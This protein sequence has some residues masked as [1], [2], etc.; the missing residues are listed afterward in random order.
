MIESMSNFLC[1]ELCCSST[2]V[3]SECA[4]G[5]RLILTNVSVRLLSELPLLAECRF[6]L[7]TI[8]HSSRDDARSLGLPQIG[9]GNLLNTRTR[10][11]PQHQVSYTPKFPNHKPRVLAYDMHRLDPISI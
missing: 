11:P 7:K 1:Y 6:D 4:I 3:F 8:V 10:Q 2:C 9:Q 5:S